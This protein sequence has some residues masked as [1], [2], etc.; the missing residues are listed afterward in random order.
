MIK[1]IISSVLMLALVFVSS[2][3]AFPKSAN[4]AN[5]TVMSD[6]VGNLTA[7]TT[8]SHVIKFTTPTGIATGKTIIL[9]FDNS[10]ST[11]GLA[12]TDVTVL[13]GA[14]PITVNAGVPTG[15]NWGFANTNPA[16]TFTTGSGTV[17]AGHVITITFNG[18]NKITNGVVGTTVL[19]IT[20][21]FGDTGAISMAIISNGVVA[22]SAEVLGSISFSLSNNA[23][24][25]GRLG[26]G[27]N[28]YA[29]TTNPPGNCT[30]TTEVE[31]INFV[32]GTNAPTG[33]TVSIQG[34][35]LTS[36]ANSIT[37]LPAAT[38]PTPG[39]EQFGISIT[40]AG[41]TGVVSSPYATAGQ[42][43]YTATAL[44]PATLA[45][46]AAATSNTTYSVRYL[47][48]IAALTEAGSYST[49][50]TYVATGNF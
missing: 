44:T 30:Q 26:T 42:F 33:Y 2:G 27:T 15:A 17:I 6:T 29:T 31:A 28:C 50:N 46:A 47:A 14:N 23:I 3:F 4:A 1:K 32:A 41:G 49:S 21:N 25:F 12:S 35:T 11:T 24:Y 19:R 39:G 34:D 37:A 22:V 7:S 48:N 13:D 18:T 10:T 20:G 8:S 40:K 5:L 45:T 16:I 38:A 9:T 36:G 43:A